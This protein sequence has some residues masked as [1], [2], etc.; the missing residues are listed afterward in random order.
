MKVPPFPQRIEIELASACNLRCTY[1]P[2]QF[3]D[4][5][6]GFMDYSLFER[7]I[8][9]ITPHPETIIVLHRRGESLLHPRFI[10]MM[11]Y[12]KGKFRE[13]QLATNATLLTPEKALAII[14]A[15]TFL[16]FSI[17]TPERFDRTRIPARYEEVE[18]KILMFLDMNEKA[19][20]PVKTQVSMVRTED[21]SEGDTA[22]FERS[23]KGRVDRIRIY[24]EHSAN[25]NFGSLVRKRPERKPCVMPFYEMLIYCDGRIGRCNHDWNGE[26]IGDIR[27]TGIEEIWHSEVYGN[28]RRQ[29]ESLE[30]T[31]PVCARCDSWY[32]EIGVQGTGKVIDDGRK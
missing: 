29:H 21:A 17:D 14:E 32:P 13:I 6:H 25:G 23:W 31:D 26:P 15:V 4:D 5:L 30:I 7:I 22:L 3:V 10:D 24:E 28:L 16:S 20:H 18:R 2:R 12:V 8:D 27:G 1:C 11:E 9:E 19:G